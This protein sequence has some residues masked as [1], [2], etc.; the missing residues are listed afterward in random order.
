M[1]NP[2]PSADPLTGLLVSAICR[3]ENTA[4]MMLVGTFYTNLIL[5]GII[6][7]I[8]AMPHWLRPLS[9]A[10]PQTLPTDTLRHILS[11]GWDISE[12]GVLL[13]FGVTIGWLA[14]F[15]ITAGLIFKYSG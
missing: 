12:G 8:E 9:Y 4:V 15:L 14:T 13:G 6:W 10:Q 1:A 11:R 7:P 5:A 2:D 3:E